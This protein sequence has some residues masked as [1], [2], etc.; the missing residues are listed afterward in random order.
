ML[1]AIIATLGLVA[2]PDHAGA[3]NWSIRSQ[4]TCPGHPTGASWTN[5]DGGAFWNDAQVTGD[6]SHW[7]VNTWSWKTE[8]YGEDDG[9]S[10]LAIANT[11]F[12]YIGG[13]WKE[14]GWHTADFFSGT[15]H[16][17]GQVLC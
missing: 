4:V 10:G 11:E 1:V 16:T 17:D 3:A 2:L 8:S 9:S 13:A 5:W 12:G 7:N 14:D 6:L 15:K